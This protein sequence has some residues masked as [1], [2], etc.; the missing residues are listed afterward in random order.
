MSDIGDDGG[1][2]LRRTLQWS[3]IVLLSFD[4][5][6][7]KMTSKNDG[8]TCLYAHSEEKARYLFEFCRIVHQTVIRIN[9]YLSTWREQM[10]RMFFKN[11]Y[12]FK[13]R[14]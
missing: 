14:Y 11:L 7:L 4:K 5:R 9:H 10:E 8:C 2:N 12:F 13:L 6:K 1:R 3:D